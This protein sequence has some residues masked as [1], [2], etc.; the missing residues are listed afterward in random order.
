MMEIV[1]LIDILANL[2]EFNFVEKGVSKNFKEV[3]EKEKLLRHFTHLANK[4]YS[5]IFGKGME[6]N[7]SA[8]SLLFIYDALLE[9]QED[10]VINVDQCLVEA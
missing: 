5:Y 2:A 9:S 4:H 10:A 6:D 8:L 3:K 7:N 1:D